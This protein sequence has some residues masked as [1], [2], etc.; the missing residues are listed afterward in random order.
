MRGYKIV[1]SDPELDL[2]L[3]V[4]ASDWLRSTLTSS[5]SSFSTAWI[6]D[7][8]VSRFSGMRPVEIEL[9]ISSEITRLC[10][11]GKLQTAQRLHMLSSKLPSEIKLPGTISRQLEIAY[12]ITPSSF[13]RIPTDLL[14]GVRESSNL[15]IKNIKRRLNELCLT[16]ELPGDS[17]YRAVARVID[18]ATGALFRD[19]RMSQELRMYILSILLLNSYYLTPFYFF[20]FLSASILRI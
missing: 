14:A 16:N 7:A 13:Y 19:Q 4:L 5:G 15:H 20:D 3:F 17:E 12:M 8:F 11:I 10:K 2:S 1:I 6:E 9:M 18:D